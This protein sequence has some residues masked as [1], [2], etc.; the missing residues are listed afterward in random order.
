MGIV[1]ENDMARQFRDVAGRLNQRL[2]GLA[3][4]VYLTVAGIP[5]KIK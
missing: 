5:V 3:D 4:A 2:A 1:P